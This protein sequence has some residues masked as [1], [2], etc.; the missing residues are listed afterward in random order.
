MLPPGGKMKGNVDVSA[1]LPDTMSL[2]VIVRD[3]VGSIRLAAGGWNICQSLDPLTGELL[4]IRQGLQFAKEDGFTKIV[5]ESDCKAAIDLLKRRG[6][7]LSVQGRITPSF[8]ENR[9][10]NDFLCF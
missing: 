4:A 5:L 1:R 8:V 7:V 3:H 10:L 9:T 2:G 6:D